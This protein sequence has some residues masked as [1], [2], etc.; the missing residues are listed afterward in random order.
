M[1]RIFA[2]LNKYASAPNKTRVIGIHNRRGDVVTDPS[3][4]YK[5]A[6]RE[7]FTMAMA[8]FRRRDYYNLGIT[9]VFLVLGEDFKGNEEMFADINNTFVLQPA[10]DPAED[11][12]LLTLCDGVIMTSGTY[13]WWAGFLNARP[14]VA[15]RL[16]AKHGN[17]TTWKNLTIDFF[18][19][20]SVVL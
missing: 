12:C 7:Y 5:L 13:S 9:V 10:P 14:S 17:P 16:Y 2:T 3:V 19:P 8:Y 11:M 18:A 6:D 15:S 20:N 1:H 4:G